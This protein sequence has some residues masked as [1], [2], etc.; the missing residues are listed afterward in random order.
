MTY[1]LHTLK[2]TFLVVCTTKLTLAIINKYYAI[3]CGLVHEVLHDSLLFIE[4]CSSRPKITDILDEK[5]SL[6]FL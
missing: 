4:I 6:T 2:N 1:S 5:K 3:F